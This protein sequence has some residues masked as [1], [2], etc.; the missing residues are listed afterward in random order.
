MK[1]LVLL[2]LIFGASVATAQYHY[3]YKTGNSYNTTK[4]GNNTYT[5]GYNA[6]TGS[7]WSARTDRSGNMNGFDSKGNSWNYNKSTGTYINYGTGEMH[8]KKQGW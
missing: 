7:N 6:N 1:Y 4:S 2:S 8:N 3:D 5:N